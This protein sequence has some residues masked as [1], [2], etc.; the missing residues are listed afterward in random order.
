MSCLCEHC[1]GTGI[2]PA[3]PA[4]VVRLG[5]VKLQPGEGRVLAALLDSP[6][7]IVG[8]QRLILLMWG[9]AEPGDALN[10][11]RVAISRL[12]KSLRHLGVEIVN[13]SGAGYQLARAVDAERI[14]A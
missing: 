14:V 4:R 11:L 10:S 12:R 8:Y 6:G 7:A 3:A 2:A 13:V 1:G 5:D 9:G